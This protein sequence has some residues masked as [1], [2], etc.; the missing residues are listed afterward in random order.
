MAQDQWDP[1]TGYNPLTEEMTMEEFNSAIP[2]L[3]EMTW[4]VQKSLEDEWGLPV[5]GMA[6]WENFSQGAELFG[7]HIHWEGLNAAT[8][9]LGSQGP[10]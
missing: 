7:I 4:N 6:V 3:R 10:L 1:I 2:I 8:S 9:S 5:H